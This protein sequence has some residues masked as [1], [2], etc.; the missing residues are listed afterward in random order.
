[1]HCTSIFL[2]VPS[3]NFN[4]SKMLL[5]DVYLKFLSQNLYTLYY[6]DY[7]G[8]LCTRECVTKSVCSLMSVYLIKISLRISKTCCSYTL[9]P[10]NYDPPVIF[11]FNNL[12][13]TLTCLPVP[14]QCVAP[15]S[16]TLSHK[17]LEKLNQR[18]FLN[19]F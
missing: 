16:G 2:Q 7:I 5:P 13:L 1:M 18:T 6:E 14:S 8:F 3:P 15:K 9:L 19:P 10:A 4:A 17:N 12:V 11:F